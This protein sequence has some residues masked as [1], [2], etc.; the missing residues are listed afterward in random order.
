MGGIQVKEVHLK[1]FRQAY[2]EE[3]PGKVWTEFMTQDGQRY[4]TFDIPYADEAYRVGRTAE[5][6]SSIVKVIDD[7]A[8]AVPVLCGAAQ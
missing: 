7:A 2:L 6:L 5:F 3:N 4:Q 8:I 1:W